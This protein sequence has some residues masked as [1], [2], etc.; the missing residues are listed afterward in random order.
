LNVYM[1]ASACLYTLE[2]LVG[3]KTMLRIMRTFQMRFRYHHP[4]T[5]DFI[6]V[7]NEV[8]DQDISWFF[9]ELFFK[10]LNF[11]YGITSLS[12]QEKPKYMPGV[13]DKNGQKEELTAQEIKE[14]G[15]KEKKAAK[16]KLYI[17]RVTVRRF[18]EACLRGDA[19]L[20]LKVVFEDG[21]E[22]IRYWKGKERWKKFIFEKSAK[23][24]YAQ[25][26]PDQIWLIDSNLTNNSFRVK[27]SGKGILKLSGKLLFWI[28]NYLQLL[29]AW[30]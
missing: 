12:S 17:T 9:D 26:D 19:S 24:K 28:Q 21:T 22:E 10:T 20:K 3:E 23:A 7:V 1:R 8:T 11:D 16:R 27:S 29:A 14:M 6:D 2:R 25:L 5:Q 13:F 15:K 4:H 30:S 18:G